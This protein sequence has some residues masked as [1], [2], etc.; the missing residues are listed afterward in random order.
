M[1][2]IDEGLDTNKVQQIVES[3]AK[4]VTKTPQEAQQFISGLA[5]AVSDDSAK[6]VHFG[7][8]LF[9][10]IVRGQGMVEV[11]TMTLDENPATLAENFNKLVQY[12]KALEVR[13]AYT[14][15]D[16]PKFKRLAKMTKLP[17]KTTESEL[18]GGQK[19]TVY[20]MELK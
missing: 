6:L 14:Y 7:N 15:T 13:I 11:H 3:Y 2:G 18:P 10:I 8:T 19:V 17:F 5:A 1:D 9:L 16:D 12:L 20:Y 4:S